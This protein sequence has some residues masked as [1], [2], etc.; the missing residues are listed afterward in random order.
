M[1]GVVDSRYWQWLRVVSSKE[2][3]GVNIEKLRY[4]R[5]GQWT[6]PKYW[7]IIVQTYIVVVDRVRRRRVIIDFSFFGDKN[8]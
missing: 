4:G 5:I 6:L 2:H 1:E 7:N 3:S 8:V